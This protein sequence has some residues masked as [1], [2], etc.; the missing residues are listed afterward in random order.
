MTE[1]IP[2]AP[3]SA[4]DPAAAAAALGKAMA[5]TKEEFPSAPIPDPDLVELPGGVEYDGKVIR[6]ARVREL[7]GYAEE[8]IFRAFTSGNIGHVLS[9]ILECG[10]ESFEGA[11]ESKTPELLKR[12]VIGD[13]EALLI[14]IRC[15]TYGDDVEVEQWPCP[16]CRE[17]VDLKLNLREDVEVKAFDGEG[18]ASEHSF[19]VPLRK[20][21]KARVRF[22]NG[23]DQEA[24]GEDGNRTVKERNTILLQRVIEYV[25]QPNGTKMSLS[26]FPS[27]ALQMGVL[28]REKIILEIAEK[29]PRLEY[30]DIKFTHDSCG[31]EVSLAL[32]LADEFLR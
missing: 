7:N 6:H 31:K 15:A 4:V 23:E 10:V 16:E 21:G 32:N 28:D 14:G 27:Y 20:G 17:P 12:V 18:A 22:P 26:A 13:R 5:S 8:K 29:N 24:A 30:D 2:E 19:D 9:V 1:Q 11:P 25:E 3:L